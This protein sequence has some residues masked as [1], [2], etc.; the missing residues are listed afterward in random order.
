MQ[1]RGVLLMNAN[2]APGS[3]KLKMGEHGFVWIFTKGGGSHLDEHRL[4]VFTQFDLEKRP[5]RV[6]YMGMY[7]IH[8]TQVFLPGSA[9][10]QLPKKVRTNHLATLSED[11][12]SRS[13]LNGLHL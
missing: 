11:A 12:N 3:E 8:R 5:E 13:H 10:L 2:N 6:C 9:W 1:R 4:H 7:D